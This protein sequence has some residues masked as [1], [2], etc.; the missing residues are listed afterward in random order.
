MPAAEATTADQTPRSALRIAVLGPGGVGGLLAAL[1]TV[2]GDQVQCLAGATTVEALSRQPLRVS[3]GQFGELSAWVPAA[4]VLAEPV[5]VCLVTVK[6]PDLPAALS[7]VPSS[8]L[9]GALIVPLLNGVEHVAALRRHYPA[10]L[11]VAATIRVES[12]RLAPGEIRHDSPFATLQLA[13]TAA[14]LSAATRFAVHLR[15][16]GP[17][18]EV[19]GGEAQVLWQKLCFLVPMALL[20][21]RA[22]APIG[23]VRE[24]EPDRLRAVVGEVCAVARGAGATISD[25]AVLAQLESVPAGMRSSMQRD[26]AA[27][28]IT[29]LDSIG[30]AVLRQAAASGVDVPA[31]AALVSE[32]AAMLPGG[33]G[34]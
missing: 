12:T 4:E 8:V 11:V 23:A 20:T 26:A 24:G 17:D 3:S 2:A 25:S 16:A 33:A 9:G 6:N 10:A 30:G 31:I 1:L 22:Q 7:R 18:A 34:T 28:R 14:S 15:A 19:R 21:T 13:E 29:E 27:G 32:L 5:D